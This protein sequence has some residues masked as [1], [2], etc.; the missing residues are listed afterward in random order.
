MRGKESEFKKSYGGSTSANRLV[1]PISKSARASGGSCFE[2]RTEW[3]HSNCKDYGHFS[4]Q[5]P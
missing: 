3:Q 1:S 5:C 2:T 4:A